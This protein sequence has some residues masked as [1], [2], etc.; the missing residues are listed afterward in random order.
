MSGENFVTASTGMPGLSVAAGAKVFGA[1]A[2]VFLA[3]TVAESFAEKLRG[4]D[5]EVVRAG[6]N[7]EASMQAALMAASDNGWVLLLDTSWAEYLETP[8][9]LIEGSLFLAAEPVD[10]LQNPP[11]NLFLQ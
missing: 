11:T 4:P 2:V 1:K 10:K 6:D 5:A 8:H 7:Y 3:D 9:E